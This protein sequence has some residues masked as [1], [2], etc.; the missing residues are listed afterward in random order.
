MS[1][2]VA[3]VFHQFKTE[4]VENII[5]KSMYEVFADDVQVKF[6]YTDHPYS[7]E[8]WKADMYLLIWD[9]SLNELNGRIPNI[10]Q[11]LT[12]SRTLPKSALP[13]LLSIPKGADVLVVNDSDQLTMQ[14]TR[15][16]MSLGFD[17]IHWIPYMEGKKNDNNYHSIQYAVSTNEVA[18]VP[19]YIPNVINVGERLFD[20]YTMTC[21]LA[22]LHLGTQENN[23]RLLK[24]TSKLIEPTSSI[25]SQY[26]G[27]YLKSSLLEDYVQHREDGVVLTDNSFRVLYLNAYAKLLFPILEPPFVT[28]LK[29]IL[30]VV[31]SGEFST[32]MIKLN[33]KNYMVN[34][35]P[36]WQENTII[37]FCFTFRDEKTIRDEDADLSHKLVVSG[38]RARYTFDH[39]CYSSQ[40]ISQLINRAHMAAITD[41]PVLIQGESGTGKELFAQSIHNASPRQDMPFVA[42]NCAA[43]PPSLLE[44]ELFGYEGGSFTGARRDGKAGLMEQA[45]G[46]TLFL[47]EVGDMSYDLQTMLLRV[48]QEKQIMRIGSDRLIPIDIRII[49]ATNRDMEEDLR[50][51]RFRSDL[52]YRLNTLPFNVPPLRERP[53]DIIVLLNHFLGSEFSLLN[54]ENREFLTHY[55]WPGNVRELE[56]FS[57][58]FKTM[59]TLKGFFNAEATPW[60][61]RRENEDL[62]LNETSAK[63]LNMQ[64]SGTSCTIEDILT[65]I[66]QHTTPSHGIGRA[67]IRAEFAARG[68]NVSE[69]WIRNGLEQLADDG[70]ITTDKGRSGNR[71]TQKGLQ[72]LGLE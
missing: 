32:D 35:K 4:Q 68:I 1:K 53:E 66:G 22:K 8:E 25:V 21:I 70:L 52:F 14:L 54:D 38:M 45:N 49:A 10:S 20:S 64:K 41:Y 43:M 11:V 63:A 60:K 46:G 61:Y 57:N 15:N 13:K 71:I 69:V 28:G 9:E 12:I 47:D 27:S 58:Y 56:N 51:R 24:Y 40:S 7:Q 31:C 55:S 29:E 18:R 59:H 30:P 62:I 16:L 39:I 33:N 48:L 37:G 44:S 36:V 5:I 3:V 17:D 65:L 34:R 50:T 42:I 67:S 26:L 2:Q 72:I 19:K 6:I 23:A